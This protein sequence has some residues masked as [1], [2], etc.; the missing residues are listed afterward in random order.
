MKDIFIIVNGQSLPQTVGFKDVWEDGL[1]I[2]NYYE[3][4][5]EAEK[6]LF[7]K[8]YERDYD[9]VYFLIESPENKQGIAKIVSL[10]KK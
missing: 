4:K 3:S 5:I 8:G 1:K 7:N 10:T 6:Y 9:G 2:K